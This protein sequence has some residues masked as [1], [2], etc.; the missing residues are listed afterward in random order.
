MPL[1][2]CLAFSK[3]S[4]LFYYKGP[5]HQLQVSKLFDFVNM[6]TYVKL[7]EPVGSPS[8]SPIHFNKFA[9]REIPNEFGSIL[10]ILF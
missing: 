7:T 6:K 9:L 8:I 2:P 10:V 5:T 1:Y 3:W 4:L